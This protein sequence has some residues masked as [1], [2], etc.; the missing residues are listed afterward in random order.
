[1]IFE[2]HGEP[3]GKGRPRVTRG[4]KHTYTPQKTKDYESYVQYCFIAKYGNL[5]PIETDVKMSMYIVYGVTKSTS[6]KDRKL[7]LEGKI[8][9]AKKPDIDNIVKAI[10]DALNGL[11]YLDDKQIVEF[12]AVKWYGEEPMVRVMIEEI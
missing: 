5:M 11:A 4:G 6:K 2:I 10:A 3:Q 12:E 8:R 9:P 1:M 7:M